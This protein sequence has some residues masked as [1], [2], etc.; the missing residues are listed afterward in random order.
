MQPVRDLGRSVKMVNQSW[1][2]V[3]ISYSS[4][5]KA[6]GAISRPDSRRLEPWSDGATKAQPITEIA[7]AIAAIRNVTIML[8]H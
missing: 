6:P 7:K 3:F 2:G 4:D 1:P 5:F 8:L